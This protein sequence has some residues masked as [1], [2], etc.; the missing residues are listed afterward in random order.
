MTQ[1][2]LSKPPF[3]YLHDIF[4]ATM[5]ATG[6]AQGLYD[7]TELDSKSYGD[8]DTKV[9]F[10]AK[11]VAVVELMVG[12]K[13]DVKP[14]KVVAGLEPEKTNAFLQELFRA[15]TA[16]VDST[17]AVKQVLGIDDG[18]GEGEGG[19][20]E[21]GGD[22]AGAEQAAA[23]EEARRQAEMEAQ[24]KDEKK[25]KMEEKKR[26]MEDKKSK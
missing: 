20:E 11:M 2:L 4:T 3:R 9:T 24:M 7:E 23:E 26:K 19:D 10:L 6:F 17:P 13:L 12:E 21:G 5:G 18:E 8:K 15:A 25:R 14:T 22:D 16:G 1:K